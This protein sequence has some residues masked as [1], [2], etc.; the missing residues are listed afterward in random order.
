MHVITPFRALRVKRADAPE[1]QDDIEVASLLQKKGEAHLYKNEF[2]RAKATFDSALQ[3]KKNISGADCM[4]VASSTYCL[5]V[6]YHYLND[7]SHAKLLFQE[8]MRIHVKNDACVVRSLCWIG[9]Q[10]EK[11]NE[12]E[13]ALERYLSA[14]RIYKKGKSSIDCIVVVM[15][16]HAIGKLFEDD[17]VNLQEMALKCKWTDSNSRY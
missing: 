15:L 10:H 9:K 12:P 2:V 13:K 3:I 17:K 8:C 7:F 14:L 6:A 1:G 11:L 4:P 5:G 16:L